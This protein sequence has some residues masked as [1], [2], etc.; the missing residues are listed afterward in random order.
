MQ[1]LSRI[2]FSKIAYTLTHFIF[3]INVRNNCDHTYTMIQQQN[4][5]VKLTAEK[6]HEGNYYQT[7][8]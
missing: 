7:P 2:I 6:K 3:V 1:F 5:F 4:S 8:I